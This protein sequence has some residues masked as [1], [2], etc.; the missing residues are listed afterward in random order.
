MKVKFLGT[1]TSHGI[2][3]IGCGCPVCMS[4]NPKNKRFRASVHARQKETDIVI[5]MPAEYRLRALEYGIDKVDGVL[6]THAHAD[7]TAGL[8]EIRRYN[9]LSGMAM[10]LYTSREVFRD[11]Q[12]RFYYM[13]EDTQAGGGKPRVDFV[14]VSPYVPFKIKET[15]ILPLAVKHG[16][17]D[18]LS[19]R[20]GGFVYMTDVSQI[21]DKTFEYLDNVKVLVLDALRYKK[22]PTH[23]N[24]DRAID[25]AVKI[26]AKKTYFTHM[27]HALEHEETE[28]KLPPQI[29]L[30]YDGMEVDV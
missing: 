26:G 13:F 19:F 8:D 22:H 7:H 6:L 20:I 25:A 12:K 30:A 15:E 23:F 21:P 3:V 1:G 2:P 29:R 4:D 16:C 18:I 17:L 10:K 11:I 14:N 27:A 24:L 9:E 28:K 5:D